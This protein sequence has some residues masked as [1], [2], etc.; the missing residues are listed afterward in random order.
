MITKKSVVRCFGDNDALYA[1]YHDTEWGRPV[2]DDHKLFESLML[3]SMQSGLSF[4]TVLKKRDN[5][6]AAFDHFHI[7]TVAQMSDSDLEHLCQNPGIIR[8]RGKIFSLSRSARICQEIQRD[9]GSLR[10][11]FW[12]Y[13]HDQ[14]TDNP[15]LLACQVPSSTP[16]SEQISQDLRKRGMIYI[17]PTSVYAFMQAV[18]MV[19]DHLRDCWVRGEKN[20]F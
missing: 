6:R 15:W 16:V 20:H 19:N 11:Y 3:E 2:H 18:G 8:H 7:P 4:L 12:S 5:Y 14:P 9:F 10:N 17:G 1:Q 13:I